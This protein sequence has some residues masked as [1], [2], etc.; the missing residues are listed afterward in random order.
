[1][2]ALCGAQLAF[3]ASA[4]WYHV[5]LY[6]ASS[7]VFAATDDVADGAVRAVMHY[8]TENFCVDQGLSP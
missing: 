8:P 6:M 7:D 5:S 2:P 1:M 3:L 4:G